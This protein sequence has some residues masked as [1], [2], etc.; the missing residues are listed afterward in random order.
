[1][2]DLSSLARDQVG[3]RPPLPSPLLGEVWSPNQWIIGEVCRIIEEILKK[4]IISARIWRMPRSLPGGW[5]KEAG[6]TFQAETVMYIKVQKQ[7]A[8]WPILGNHK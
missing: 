6:R 4:E 5:D 7:Y 2:Q 3:T 1:M 8:V